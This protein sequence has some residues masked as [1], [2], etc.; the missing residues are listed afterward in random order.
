MTAKDTRPEEPV[1]DGAAGNVFWL[2][3]PGAVFG[4]VFGDVPGVLTVGA[5][6]AAGVFAVWSESVIVCL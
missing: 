5:A 2:A 6:G 1:D 4:D 3:V